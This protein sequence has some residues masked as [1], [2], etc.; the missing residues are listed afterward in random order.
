MNGFNK[1]KKKLR[2]KNIVY[3]DRYLA[4]LK[5]RHKGG[6]KLFS[7]A[8]EVETFLTEMEKE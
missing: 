4:K 1:V 8:S 5:I 7:T 3:A 6:F 2:E